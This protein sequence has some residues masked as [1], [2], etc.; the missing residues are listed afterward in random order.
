LVR[1]WY[2]LARFRKQK[3]IT[4]GYLLKYWFFV[5]KFALTCF[6]FVFYLHEKARKGKEIPKILKIPIVG[7]LGILGKQRSP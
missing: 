3:Y 4:I 6:Y 5:P 7:I 1:L 2:C